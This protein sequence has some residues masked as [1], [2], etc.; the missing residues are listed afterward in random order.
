MKETFEQ[1]IFYRLVLIS[2][3]FIQFYYYFSY[4]FVNC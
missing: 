2:K 1:Y 4:F 3:V